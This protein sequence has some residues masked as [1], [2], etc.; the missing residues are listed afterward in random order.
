M[1]LFHGTTQIIKEIDLSKGRHRTDF[2]KGF[3]LGSNLDVAE[4]WAKNRAS[5]SG[6][7]IVMRYFLDPTIF[8]DKAVNPL[9]FDYPSASWLDFV[10][11]NRRKEDTDHP[12]KPRHQHGVVRGPIA[13]DKV[14]FV[15]ED[16]ING[17]ITACE[18]IARAK[19]MPNALQISLHSEV[20]LKY[21]QM[22]NTQYKEFMSSG[23]WSE[24]K[25]I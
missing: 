9:C 23:I 16:Y 3:Y 1:I 21:V 25:S 7:P 6:K 5:F 13:N 4:K 17:K 8:S 11:D 12:H 20:A 18:A 10:R 14:N 15:V 24:W 2:G 19:A 22:S